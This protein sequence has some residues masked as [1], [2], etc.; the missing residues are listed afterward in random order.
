[1]HT[2]DTPL[3]TLVL[4]DARGATALPRFRTAL[5]GS[6]SLERSVCDTG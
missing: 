4:P 3:R 5:V 2:S 6:S 1:M